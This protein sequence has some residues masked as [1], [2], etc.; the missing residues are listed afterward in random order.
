MWQD[1]SAFVFAQETSSLLTDTET[2]YSNMVST[3]Q[4][5]CPKKTGSPDRGP[6]QKCGSSGLWLQGVPE[7]AAAEGRWEGRLLH[8]V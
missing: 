6:A 1:M 3:R 4:Q 2:T 8:E 7:L 5:A